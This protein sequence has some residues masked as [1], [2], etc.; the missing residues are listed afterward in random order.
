MKKLL[1]KGISVL[2]SILLFFTAGLG[3]Y[4]DE[5]KFGDADGD[6]EVTAQDA[7]CISRHLNRFRMMDAAALSRADFDGD[8]VVTEHD[9]SLILSS[10]MSSDLTVSAT[11][12]FS[13]LFTSG[14]AGN[15]WDPASTEDDTSCTAVHTATYIQNCRLTDPDLLLFDVGGSLFGSSVA[16]EYTQNTQQPYGPITLLFLRMKYNSVL[17]GDE[18]FSYP[19][20]TVR[21]EVNAMQ[22]RG[23]PVLGANFQKSDPTIFDSYGALWNDIFSYVIINVPQGEGTEPL[24]VAAQL[25]L[26]DDQV[27]VGAL[28]LWDVVGISST[29]FVCVAKTL[30]PKLAV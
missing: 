6:S 11:S 17:L 26:S 27:S 19:S 20:Q 9:S 16:D 14:L 3:S 30:F 18:A 13:M 23:L 2:F 15:A 4:A 7:S 1:R 28:H 5:V 8:G 29:V 22:E 24:R 21:R 10:F 25:L 12:S